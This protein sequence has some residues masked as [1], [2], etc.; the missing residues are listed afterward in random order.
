MTNLL[1]IPDRQKDYESILAETWVL[2]KGF[3]AITTMYHDHSADLATYEQVYFLKENIDYR[4][5]SASHQ[6]YIFLKQLIDSENYLSKVYNENPGYVNPNT[7]PI[8]NPYFEKVEREMSTL[9]DNLVF[10]LSSLFD[11]LSHAVCYMFFR[12]KEATLNWTK[13]AR[14]VRG[15]LKGEFSFCATIDKVDREFV[16]KLYDYRSRL[17]HQKRDRHEFQANIRMNTNIGFELKIKASKV[18]LKHFKIADKCT[19]HDQQNMT[20]TYLSSILLKTTFQKIEDILESVK[21]DLESNSKFHENLTKKTKDGGFRHMIMSYDKE[22]NMSKPISS[23]L[24]EQ[25]LSER[26]RSLIPK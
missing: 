17:L 18:A 25:F 14:K 4:L 2:E 19:Q 24:W 7:F 10:H 21:T 11:Y 3:R 22:T 16:A 13:L 1:D 12:N 9:F 20:L 5:F 23:V 8:G 15:D 26:N 6:Y